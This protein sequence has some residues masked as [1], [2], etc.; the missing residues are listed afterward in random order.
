MSIISGVLRINNVAINEQ[1]FFKMVEISKKYNPDNI[2]TTHN[3]N[4]EIFL[5][6][7]LIHTTRNSSKQKVSYDIFNRQFLIAFD[8]NLHDR[9]ELALKLEIDNDNVSDSYLLLRAYL[10]WDQ[11]FLKMINGNF[12]FS[13]WDDYNKTL[14]LSRDR[15]GLR[16]LY[17]SINSNYISWA[18]DI[19][20]LTLTN[21]C[22]LNDDFIF[23]YLISDPYST[24]ETIY[25]SIVRVEPGQ[26]VIIKDGKLSSHQYYE[27][28]PSKINFKSENEYIEMFFELY[29]NSVKNTF[30]IDQPIGV[31]LSGGLDSS[32]FV[33]LGYQINPSADI[34]T[35]SYTF[36]EYD[37]GNEDSY[38]NSL[39]DMYPVKSK[40]IKADDLWYLKGNFSDIV[41][42]LDEPYPHFNDAFMGE[43]ANR[44]KQDGIKILVSGIYGDHVLAGNMKQFALLIK[45]LKFYTLIREYQ[46]WVRTGMKFKRL[47]ID[48]SIMPLLNNK[49]II[50]PPW[51][52]ENI[53]KNGNYEEVINDTSMQNNYW[54]E[55]GLSR[56]IKKLMYG[57]G[58]EWINDFFKSKGVEIRLPFLD[59]KLIEFMIGVPDNLK[60]KPGVT[61]YLLRESFEGILPEKIRNRKGKSDHEYLV[62]KGFKKEWEQITEYSDFKMLKELGYINPDYNYQQHFD[63]YYLGLTVEKNNDF[64]DLMRALALEVW[65]RNKNLKGGERICTENQY[66]LK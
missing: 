35:Y 59:H 54:D 37:R 3:S 29:K 30:D 40:F 50:I 7:S 20:Q 41:G 55:A 15:L 36:E 19:K 60:M 61:K 33:S 8:G 16:S 62:Q 42:N 1:N 48:H 46:S 47:F 66:L 34:R 51:L 45:R 10:K 38:I 4:K 27:C 57:V 12:A 22:E 13:I 65:L 24:S 28:K 6:S 63:N 14:I 44:S 26:Y 25:K 9:D 58:T 31:A 39:L 52:N 5:A 64:F 53:K 2:I 21:N 43:I 17:Y 18:S 56:Y 11:S 49:K 23:K 32:S